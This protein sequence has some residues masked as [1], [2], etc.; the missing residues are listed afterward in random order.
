MALMLPGMACSN[1]KSTSSTPR[2]LYGT[3]AV[4]AQEIG[5][6]T[7]PKAAFEK[8]QLIIHDSIYTFIAES[9][10]KGIVKI[11]GDKMDIYS[12]EG[13]NAGRHF[14]AIYKHENGI[15]TICYNLR[16]DSYP[17]AFDTKEHPL[18]FLSV[19][20]KAPAK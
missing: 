10:D 11:T 18:F 9:I 17:E 2:G 4:S 7:L 1:A 16:G 14:T 5:G 3:W 20:N 12:N 19:F 13:V 15:L 6:K 8:Q